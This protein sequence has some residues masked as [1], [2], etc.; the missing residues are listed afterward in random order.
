MHANAYLNSEVD[1][2]AMVGLKTLQEKTRVP[3]DPHTAIQFHLMGRTIIG[4][5]K[6]SILEI[7]SLPSLR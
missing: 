3:M 6:Q 4:D 2:L 1:K 7:L 5:Y